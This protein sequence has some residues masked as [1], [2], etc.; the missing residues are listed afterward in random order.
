MEFSDQ[1]YIE[2]AVKR[3]LSIIVPT[4][5]IPQECRFIIMKVRDQYRISTNIDFRRANAA[6]NNLWKTKGDFITPSSVLLHVFEART[7]LFFA[8]KARAEVATSPSNASIID[9][10]CRD[11]INTRLK[12]QHNIEAFQEMVLA[13]GHEI[14]QSL[15]MNYRSWHEFLGLL[16]Q[17]RRFKRDFL[18]QK[19]PDASLINEY[20]KALSKDTWVESLPTKT[21]RF[22]IFTVAET[23]LPTLGSIGLSAADTFLVDRLFGGWKPNQF[24]DGPLKGFARLD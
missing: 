12:S 21:L 19:R 11:I 23:I 22:L 18:Q 15:K 5:Q 7:D 2:N 1:A 20:Y 17:A 6:F 9:L 4:Y 10:K 16:K 8:S 13:N 24:V 3:L 14:G